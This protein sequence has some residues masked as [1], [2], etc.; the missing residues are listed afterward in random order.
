MQHE[1]S[2]PKEYL[3]VIENDWKKEKIL[4]LR[5]LILQTAPNIEESIDYKMLSYGNNDLKAIYLNAQK[6]FVGLYV[7]DIA[8]ID[9]KGELLKGVDCGKGC[10]RIK[11]RVDVTA[12]N[13]KKVIE[14]TIELWR[15]NVDLKC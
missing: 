2:T 15:K 10:V 1:A 9:P 4:Y 8:R 5:E 12:E 3:Q 6:N 11:K 13:F 7:G 14:N